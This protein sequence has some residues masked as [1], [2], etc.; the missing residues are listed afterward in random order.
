MTGKKIY[1][2]IHRTLLKFKWFLKDKDK[3]P[4]YRIFLELKTT[5][6]VHRCIPTHYFTHFLYRKKNENYLD[7][8]CDKEAL[9]TH[10]AFHQRDTIDILDNKLLFHEHFSK[11][12]I[13]LPRRLGYNLRNMWFPDGNFGT[14][15]SRMRTSKEF[16]AL[17]Q[18]LF[19]HSGCVSIFVK[20]LRG[21]GGR[22]VIRL[23][24]DMLEGGRGAGNERT[25]Q[26]ITEGSYI[27]EEQIIQH[28]DMDRLYP[29]SLNTIRID[30][31]VDDNDNPEVLAAF[32]RMGIAGNVV[33]NAAEG[34]IMA[35]ID[36]SSGRLQG[37]AQKNL[38][39]GGT[40]YAKH[41]DSG[42]AFEGF[43][44][45]YFSEVKAMACK[46]AG[47]ISYRLVGWDIGIAANGPVLIEGNGWY[48]IK[49][50]QMAYGG[51]RRHPVFRKAMQAAGLKVKG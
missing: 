1:E 43:V 10:R 21:S 19:Q 47:Q 14:H 51:Y 45:P 32:L 29:L 13:E 25:F 49:G 31:F 3:K 18:T 11:R 26:I 17:V 7:Y 40:T 9:K 8:I 50:S 41:P 12:G 38:V 39:Q 24:R 22:G 42:V 37:F 36:M 27:F 20:P 30:T 2:R 16:L 33:D 35:G 6:F 23:T 28:S 48:T 34:G 4:L 46:A 44:L 15:G 5:A